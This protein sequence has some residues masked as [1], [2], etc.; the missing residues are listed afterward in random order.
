MSL[1]ILLIMADQLRGDTLSCSEHPVVETPNLDNLAANGSRFSCAYSAVPSC[2]PAR[3]SLITGMNQYHTGILGMGA[4]APAMRTDY[5]HTLP[6]ELAKAGYHTQGI[7][8]MHFHPQ[9]ALN[10]FHNTILDESGR[11]QSPGFVS[12]YREWFERNKTGDYGYRDH[13][14]D[15]NSWM[16][17]PSHLPEW[18]H[19]T[20]WTAEESIRWL[21]RRDPD[22]P[23][24]LMVSFAR[25]HSPYDPPQVYYD[26]YSN[27]HMPEP[28][29]G[30]WSAMNDQ[31]TDA[32]DVNAWRGKRK[33]I[34]IQRARAAYYGSVTFIDHQ[35]GR[36]LY[37]IRRNEPDVYKNTLVIFTS[38]H[39]DMLGD[40][41]LWR[42]TY[43]YEGSTHIPLII[44][45][46]RSWKMK[47]RGVVD[48]VVGL[49]DIMP[50]ILDAAGLQIPETCD[51]KSLMPLVRGEEVTW[52]PFMHGE[53]CTCYST[54]QE[55]QYLTDGK[56]KYIWLP[57]LGVEQFFDLE[58]DPGECNDLSRD[59]AYSSEID[60]W[61]KRLI[62][63]L[64]PRECGLVEDG[65]LVQRI[66]NRAFRPPLYGCREAIESL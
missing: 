40:H 15:W 14:V 5:L 21:K 66:S 25:P 28:Y 12:D 33:D 45:P 48:E 6:G 3:A 50:S 59:P 17:R 13:G 19:P 49:S 22:K 18:L 60:L 44:T 26:M 43:A 9:R 41:H 1:N 39:G 62:D 61:R 58:S 47:T 63:E 8:K 2:I 38:D 53:H 29:I 54:D 34:E 42:K 52:R 65:K 55:M 57:G 51:G 16:A 56:K 35:I 11:V 36:L 27:R 10:G 4:G 46:P 31:P 37:E 23:F 20:H 24:F 64:A 7:G 30:H 32:C